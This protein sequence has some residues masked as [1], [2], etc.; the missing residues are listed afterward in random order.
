MKFYNELV[1]AIRDKIPVTLS[2]NNTKSYYLIPTG[3]PDVHYEWAFHGRPRSKFGVELHFEISNRG[4]NNKL[5]SEI[6]KSKEDV[7]KE[8][9]ETP[10]FQENWGRTW[11]RL[12]IEKNEGKMT[13]ELKKWAIE[14][15]IIL[16]K[17]LQPKLDKMK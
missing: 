16:Y 3:I 8:T 13:D 2:E 15:M 5:L 17:V 11:S 14:K 4:E 7:E 10:I 9:G 12:Y 6:E 1:H